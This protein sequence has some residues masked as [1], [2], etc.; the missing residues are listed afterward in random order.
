MTRGGNVSDIQGR[1]KVHREQRCRPA[2]EKQISNANTSTLN[3][4][5]P[6]PDPDVK[7]ERVSGGY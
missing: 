7:Q 1:V 4:N 2:D 6:D 5:L 3:Q